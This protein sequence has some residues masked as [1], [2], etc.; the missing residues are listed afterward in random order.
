MY[1]DG[2]GDYLS[3][4]DSSDFDVAAGDFTIEMWINY[5]SITGAQ[6][7]VNLHGQTEADRSFWWGRTSGGNMF[8][9]YY[10]G[11][12]SDATAIDVSWTPVVDTWYHIA[13]SRDSANMRLFIV[14]V[15]L[16]S[17]YDIGSNAFDPSGYPLRIGVV[18]N[19]SGTLTDYFS[20]YI[21]EFRFTKGKSR[22]I[23]T[24]DPPKKQFGRP[25]L[26]LKDGSGT[27]TIKLKQI[28]YL[29]S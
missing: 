24:F 28:N 29:I 25:D 21:D 2:T 7:I 27:Y 10:Y 12:S 26:K 9:Y 17:A 13:L 14:G 1:F 15:Q 22:Y 5:S 3:I 8:V 16:G 4:P 6:A 11:G 23:G 20:G 18:E 19:T